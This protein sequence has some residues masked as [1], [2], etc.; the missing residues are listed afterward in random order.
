MTYSIVHQ[1]EH[2]YI[3]NNNSLRYTH[4]CEKRLL[5]SSCRSVS[6]SIRMEQLGYQWT[7]FNEIQYLIIFLK[8]VEG[9]LVGFLAV[10][11]GTDKL[12]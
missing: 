9:I 7:D 10:E 6:L 4:N 8:S 5:T 12:F 11:D 3:F 1:F 2:F